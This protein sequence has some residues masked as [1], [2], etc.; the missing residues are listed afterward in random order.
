[1][2]HWQLTVVVVIYLFILRERNLQEGLFS[3]LGVV[4]LELAAD[5]RGKSRAHTVVFPNYFCPPYTIK[6]NQK[7]N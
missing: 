1:M 5:R 3:S 4:R 7:P 2:D 6:Y